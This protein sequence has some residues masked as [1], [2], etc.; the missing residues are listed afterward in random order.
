[1]I[2][3]TILSSEGYEAA[4]AGNGRQAL[5]AARGEPFDVV[6][7]D[8]K[9]PDLNGRELLDELLKGP[10]RLG[11][12]ARGCGPGGASRST[13]YSPTSRCPTST[14]WSCWTSCSRPSPGCAWC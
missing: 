6:L 11:A 1:Q 12:A 5:Q 10:P 3:Q 8:L 14:A 7:T 4:A 9:M 13:W 2:L